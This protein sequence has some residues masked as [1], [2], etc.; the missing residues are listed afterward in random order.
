MQIVW[1][2][3]AWKIEGAEGISYPRVKGSCAQQRPDEVDEEHDAGAVGVVP[4][5]VLA[6]SA[7]TQD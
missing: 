2:Q 5:E 4:Q 6:Q 3:K 7:I 1:P